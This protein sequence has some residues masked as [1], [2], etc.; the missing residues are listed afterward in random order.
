MRRR[1]GPVTHMWI[2]EACKV[3]QI[4]ANN[5]I[6]NIGGRKMQKK[7]IPSTS[8]ISLTLKCALNAANLLAGYSDWR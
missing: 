4:Y 3:N 7:M 6:V 8:S 2:K 1:K 5:T